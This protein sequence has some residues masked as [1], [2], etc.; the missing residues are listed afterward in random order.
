[1]LY[2]VKWL[3]TVTHVGHV[4]QVAICGG[5]VDCMNSFDIFICQPFISDSSNI[6]SAVRR[7]HANVCC[8]QCN[9]NNDLHL[10]SPF[11]EGDV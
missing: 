1:M 7:E 2:L 4:N 8:Q 3:V 5:D 11:P 9:S 6:V 10:C